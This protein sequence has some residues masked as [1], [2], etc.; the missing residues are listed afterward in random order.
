MTTAKA[1]HIALWTAG[2]IFLTGVAV[3]AAAVIMGQ[4]QGPF[5][6]VPPHIV[7]TAITGMT[8]ISISLVTGI[9]GAIL[10]VVQV[11]GSP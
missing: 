5:F 6:R 10:K 11:K 3:F 7:N 1:V 8:L 2:A 9:A 4:S